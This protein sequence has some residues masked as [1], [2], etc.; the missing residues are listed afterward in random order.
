MDPD[1]KA[2]YFLYYMPTHVNGE[3]LTPNSM[4]MLAKNPRTGKNE[5]KYDF[6]WPAARREHGNTAV[7][8]A[9]WAVIKTKVIGQGQRVEEQKA[10]IP[11]GEEMPC[12]IDVIVANF[13]KHA[14]KGERMHGDDP[15]TYVRCREQTEGYHLVVGGFAPAGLDV[16]HNVYVIGRIGVV[17]LRKFLLGPRS[18]AS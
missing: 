18:L 14:W 10:L 7:E 11:A 6:F 16:S 2:E 5:A 1:G 13:A 3:K 4:E 17:S 8:Q 9:Y 15:L 12:A